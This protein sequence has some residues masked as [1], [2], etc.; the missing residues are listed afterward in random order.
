[1]LTP[2][3]DT[4]SKRVEVSAAIH[5]L[6]SFA[7]VLDAAG[8]RRASRSVARIALIIAGSAAVAIVVLAFVS[9]RRLRASR[10]AIAVER[11]DRTHD[12]ALLRTQIETVHEQTALLCTE[13][14]ML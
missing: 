3:G 14:E 12:I 9:L 6:V 7:S 11:D 8:R 2:R 5:P 13:V 10:R 4:S 1:V